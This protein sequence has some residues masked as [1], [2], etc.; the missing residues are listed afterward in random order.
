MTVLPMLATKEQTLKI[1]IGEDIPSIFADEPKMRQIFL[2]LISNA[3][4]FTPKKGKIKITCY[5]AEPHLL[6]CSVVDNGIGISLQDQ[7][8]IF[9]DF[10]QARRNQNIR[11]QGAGLGL[12]IAKRFVELHGGNIWVVSEVGGGSN[13]TFSTPIPKKG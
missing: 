1:E 13:F 12:S 11:G 4:R 6:C 2:N 9:E 3:H 8:R 5:L 7:P 10:G